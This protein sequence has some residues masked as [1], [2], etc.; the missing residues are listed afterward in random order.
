[1]AFGYR[2]FISATV[3]P[4]LMELMYSCNLFSGLSLLGGFGLSDTSCF[5]LPLADFDSGLAAAD[6]EGTEGGGFDA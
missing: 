2:D 3:T 4:S 6:L 5:S 1:M